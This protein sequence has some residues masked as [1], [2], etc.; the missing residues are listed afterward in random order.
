MPVKVHVPTE[1]PTFSTEPFA[2]DTYSSSYRPSAQPIFR[3]SQRVPTASKTADFGQSTN[4]ISSSVA[5]AGNSIWDE[6]EMLVSDKAQGGCLPDIM[7]LYLLVMLLIIPAWSAIQLLQ[8]PTYMY[9]FGDSL[10]AAL[11]YTCVGVI[12]LFAAASILF[13]SFAKKGYRTEQTVLSTGLLFLLGIAVALL[14]FHTSFK[15]QARIAT[16]QLYDNCK[17]GERTR[18]LYDTY[19]NLTQLRDS[20]ET[21]GGLSTV[22]RCAGYNETYYSQVLKSIESD[23][24]CSGFCYTPPAVGVANSTNSTNSS[25]LVL[26]SSAIAS[27]YPRALF[28]PLLHQ[29]SCQGM[30]G[31]HINTLIGDMATGF[32]FE[33]L[34]L[35]CATIIVGYLKL[36]GICFKSQTRNTKA[37]VDTYR[38]ATAAPVYG[39]LM[40]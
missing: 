26:N 13:A 9:L 14:I 4:P 39:T 11:L 24:M 23:L 20:N 17:G 5:Y 22:E 21:C 38:V 7:A 19:T 30:A 31:R 29:G 34:F 6:G 10:P 3:P 16:Q 28:S 40:A 25:T 12:S 8:D 27:L 35:I 15:K 2:Q 1:F 32:Q 37:L 36:F 18:Y 33:A